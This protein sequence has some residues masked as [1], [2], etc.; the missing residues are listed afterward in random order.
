MTEAR[1]VDV[2]SNLKRAGLGLALA[3]L[4]GFYALARPLEEQPLP[5]GPQSWSQRGTLFSWKGQE[6]F[7]I[8]EGQGPTL[9]CLHGFP[10]SSYDWEPLW[11]E[12]TSRY[13]VLALDF[14]GF[15]LSSKPD[16][17][18]SLFHQADLVEAV[19]ADRGV[20][21]YDLLAHDYGDTVA[22]ELLAREHPGLQ[23]VCLL[24][25]GIFMDR[26]R[27]ELIQKILK[28]PLGPLVGRLAR[29]RLFSRRLAAVFGPSTQPTQELL[30]DYWALASRSNGGHII[31]R[32]IQYM[33]ERLRHQQRWTQAMQEQRRPLRLIIGTQDPVSGENM[34]LAYEETVCEPDVVRLPGCGHYPQVEAPKATLHAILEFLAPGSD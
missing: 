3:A 11:A 8:E 1:Q 27:P 34:A 15:G 20:E 7:V 28:G 30:T 26:A 13:R 19:L 23:K 21:D 25:G 22:L 9:V 31:H 14:L 2:S 16:I 33:D 18:Y 6:I 10:T 32:V 29:R 24:N 4:G 17:P 5:P 12:L